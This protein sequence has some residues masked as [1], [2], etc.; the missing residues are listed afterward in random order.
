LGNNA[1]MSAPPSLP[2]SPKICSMAP[3]K[4]HECRIKRCGYL[5]RRRHTLDVIKEMK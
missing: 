1:I 2:T 5:G 3:Q 4:N